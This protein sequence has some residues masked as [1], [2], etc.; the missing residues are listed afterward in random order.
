MNAGVGYPPGK[1]AQIL[2]CLLFAYGK[3]MAEIAV[4]AGPLEGLKW[5]R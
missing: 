1:R 5:V 2:H 4:I 3:E